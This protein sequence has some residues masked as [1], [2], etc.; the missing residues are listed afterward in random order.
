M[1]QDGIKQDKWTDAVP[2]LLGEDLGQR[3]QIAAPETLGQVHHLV[4]GVLLL[5]GTGG[6]EERA[7]CRHGKRVTL[8]PSAGGS[9]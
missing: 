1:N 2:W 4:G 9:L 3:E 7:E 8:F 6:G 5:A